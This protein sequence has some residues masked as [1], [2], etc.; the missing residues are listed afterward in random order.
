MRWQERFSRLR[1]SHVIHFSNVLRNGKES[2]IDGSG[3]FRS[4]HIENHRDQGIEVGDRATIADVG[5]FHAEFL[6][7]TV[8]AL[9]RS[10]LGGNGS[11]QRA[12]AVQGDALEAAPFLVDVCDAAFALG[13]WLVVA[14]FSGGV[15][16]KQ[17]TLEAPGA[18][19]G[20][21]IV[22]NG[23]RHEQAI[24]TVWRAIGHEGGCGALIERDRS[25]AAMTSCHIGDRL[26]IKGRIGSDVRRE[27]LEGLDSLSGTAART[28]G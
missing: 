4:T 24:L 18:R 19:A 10:P 27:W 20:G 13:T 12:L 8:A 28:G 23:G 11:R 17:R 1:G 3:S 25:N 21:M 26:G 6:G 7:L 16:E 2:I 15:R 14:R 9:A 22:V 5:T